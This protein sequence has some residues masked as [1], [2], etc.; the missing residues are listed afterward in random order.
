MIDY[1][2]NWKKRI[3]YIILG[4]I[5]FYFGHIP[6][7][8]IFEIISLPVDH[9]TW[10]TFG[11]NFV[12]FGML[13]MFLYMAFI[14]VKPSF[15][16]Q[17]KKYRK[18]SILIIILIPT[19]SILLPSGYVI[20]QWESGYCTITSYQVSG[21]GTLQL[22]GGTSSGV[23]SESHCIENCRNIYDINSKDKENSCEFTGMYGKTHWIKSS[24]EI[25]DVT[26]KIRYGGVK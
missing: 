22:G 11:F 21:E 1:K 4:I 18:I 3:K 12:R 25:L 8:L 26:D 19:F 9:M 7:H 10:A 14:Y 15:F 2:K 20:P 23:S 6:I 16:P 5:S 24:S 13:A 17:Q